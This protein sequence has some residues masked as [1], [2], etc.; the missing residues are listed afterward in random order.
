MLVEIEANG[1]PMA[2]DGAGADGRD[3]LTTPPASSST[4]P[5]QPH[6]LTLSDHWPHMLASTPASR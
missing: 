1:D 2:A 4:H 3:G 5:F 6:L